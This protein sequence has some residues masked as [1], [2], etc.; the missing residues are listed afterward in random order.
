MLLVLQGVNLKTE[1]CPQRCSMVEVVSQV[2]FQLGVDDV[3]GLLAIIELP[4]IPADQ[5]NLLQSQAGDL[6][7]MSWVDFRAKS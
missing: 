1:G 3:A 7:A 2:A 4:H 6:M 5:H